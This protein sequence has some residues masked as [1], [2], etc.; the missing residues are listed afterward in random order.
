M[1][2]TD[3][4]VCS[5]FYLS[6]RIGEVEFKDVVGFSS[7]F[8]LNSIP[9]GS[10]SVATGREMASGVPATIHR[11]KNKLRPGDE[12]VVTLTIRNGAGATDMMEEGVYTIF[13]GKYAGIGYKRS[14]NTASYTI[15][16]VHWLD[17]LNHGSMI[18]GNWFPGAPYDMAQNAGYYAL[19][20]TDGAA[21]WE[22]SPIPAIDTRNEI[23]TIDQI[24]GAQGDF[25]DQVLRP[26][27]A[28]IAT[29]PLP[30]YQTDTKEATAEQQRPVLEALARMAANGPGQKWYKPLQLNLDGL[31]SQNTV[32]AIKAA[33]AKDALD[34]FAYTTFWNKL[35][36]EYA[37]QFYFAVSPSIDFATPIPFFAGLNTPYKLITANEYN[38]ADFNASVLQQLESVDIFFSVS[39]QTG[40]AN[41]PPNA[42]GS[43]PSFKYPVGFYPPESM[44]NRKGFKLI[45][46]PP[47]WMTNVF[48]G[49][50][51][52]S[53]STGVNGGAKTTTSPADGNN[54]KP[55][56]F[57][58]STDVTQEQI[59]SAAM[60]RFAEH[61]YKTE[62]LYQRHGEM[63]GKLRFDIAPGSI[64]GIE[65]S[66][67]DVEEQDI[68]FATV[69][70]V[71][72]AI[73]AERGAAGTSFTLAHIR[74]SAENEEPT[75]IAELPPMYKQLWR[76]APL[77]VKT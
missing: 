5:R 33:V 21:G 65:T 1:A 10:L 76:G 53:F 42:D 52:A 2:P 27:F 26:L 72:F 54:D 60:T 14:Y 6:A 70:Q 22:Q 36:G 28:K 44:Q 38:Y 9:V 30:R 71:S 64:V 18:N 19:N 68:M 63:S 56:G 59:T 11:L 31:D 74:T 29:W 49:P 17:D 75:L 69:T 77:A 55:P 67:R 37:P 43:Y 23:F 46:E 41:G 15:Q 39:D 57:L 50:L 47:G 16:L 35:V 51:W 32:W 58:T 13:R 25:W 24:G 73:D 40:F 61:W 34:S 12:A 7:T 66:P 48:A 45:K 8:G 20:F 4:Y 3:N 62:V